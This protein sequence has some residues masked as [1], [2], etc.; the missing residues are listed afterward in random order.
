MVGTERKES[1]ASIAANVAAVFEQGIG[2]IARISDEAYVAGGPRTSI[3]AHFRHNL[4]FARQLLSGIASGSVDYTARLRDER[5]AVDRDLAVREM[6]RVIAE[7]RAI[8]VATLGTALSVRSDASPETWAAS[9]VAREL[10][11][12]LSHTVHHYALIAIRLGSYGIEL[13]SDFGVAPS[14][15]EFFRRSKGEKI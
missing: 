13:P 1:A 10:D 14:T 6:R 11:F 8:P 9:S 12:L 3:G 5:I 7:L 2:V 4:E 15:I